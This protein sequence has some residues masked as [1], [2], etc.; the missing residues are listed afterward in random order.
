VAV[1]MSI[2]EF[3]DE[4][5]TSNA[6]SSWV[7]ADPASADLLGICTQLPCKARSGFDE[8]PLCDSGPYITIGL[9]YCVASP[10]KPPLTW[11]D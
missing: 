2:P 10:Y 7:A 8:L 5:V 6:A 1:V 11:L 4:A 3:S 9:M